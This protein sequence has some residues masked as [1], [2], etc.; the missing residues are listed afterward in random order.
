MKT[1]NFKSG[2]VAAAIIACFAV[3][4][5]A[6]AT[7][8]TLKADTSKMAKKS[9]KMSK[10]KMSSDKMSGDKM[11]SDKMS[12]DKM[13]KSKMSSDKMSKSK[14]KKDTSKSKM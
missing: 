5:Q 2:I 8:L 1:I 6:K 4:A 10:S 13:S 9:D 12:G 7:D 3:T 11:S 14:M